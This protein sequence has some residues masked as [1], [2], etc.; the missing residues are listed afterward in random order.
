MRELI[1]QARADGRY[2]DPALEHFLRLVEEGLPAE[3]WLQANHITDWPAD[4]VPILK[5]LYCSLSRCKIALTLDIPKSEVT[6]WVC[7]VGGRVFDGFDYPRKQITDLGAWQW[8][9]YHAG[10]CLSQ[11]VWDALNADYYPHAERRG[12]LQ[13][14]E[15]HRL[16]FQRR[17][18]FHPDPMV[19]CEGTVP[20]SVRRLRRIVYRHGCSVPYYRTAPDESDEAE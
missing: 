4:C 6:A 10:C 8:L 5:L 11:Q 14:Y 7:Y 20:P 9:D 18:R 1:E 15:Y 16:S 13:P 17:P 3:R 12:L 2:V 19:R